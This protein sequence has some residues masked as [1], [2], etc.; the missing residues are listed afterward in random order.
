MV[1]VIGVP[2]QVVP[3]L[4]KLAVT[5]KVEVNG[6]MP[7]LVATKEGTLP[8]PESGAR[9]I[10]WLVL[11]QLK[12]APATGLVNTTEGTTAPAQ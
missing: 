12:T 6:V 1:N 9:P 3:L 10:A 11:L 8:V 7:A 2:V 5:V 4:V